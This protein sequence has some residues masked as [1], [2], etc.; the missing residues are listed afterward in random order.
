MD[1]PLKIFYVD[2]SGSEKLGIA[3]LGWLELE[4]E[5]WRT[6][7]TRVLEWRQ[8]LAQAYGIPKA[9]ELHAVHFVNGRGN[10]STD[11]RW[12]RFKRHRRRI[13]EDVFSRISEWSEVD[14]RSMTEVSSLRR[15]DFQGMRQQLYE[16]FLAYAEAQMR[17]L[18]GFGIV[19]I[20]GDGS[21]F[22]Y[23]RAH[24][25]LNLETRSIVEDPFFQHSH[26]SQLI[27]LADFVAYAAFQAKARQPAKQFS[28]D[29]FELAG[30]AEK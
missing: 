7:L 22:T 28:W 6:V 11:E 24:R 4:V 19:I 10:P 26:G 23:K 15:H 1:R 12:N 9:Y 8:E 29:W 14:V 18:S 25:A 17:E 21:D 30:G 5:N 16:R 27:Q 20:D 13:A 3:V 2:D